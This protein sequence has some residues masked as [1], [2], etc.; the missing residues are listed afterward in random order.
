MPKQQNAAQ[1]G[2]DEE[3]RC[4]LARV[5]CERGLRFRYAVLRDDRNAA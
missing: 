2:E 5:Q 3:G 4:N 1:A